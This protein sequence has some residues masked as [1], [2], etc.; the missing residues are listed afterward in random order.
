MNRAKKV[1]YILNGFKPARRVRNPLVAALTFL[2]GAKPNKTRSLEDRSLDAFHSLNGDMHFL[3][4]VIVIIPKDNITRYEAEKLLLEGD[5][6]LRQFKTGT[7]MIRR[8]R[9]HGE[10]ILKLL[11][12]LKKEN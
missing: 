2:T 4:G 1:E 6:L 8:A 12:K 3:T 11:K 5:E 9:V 7:N 10:K